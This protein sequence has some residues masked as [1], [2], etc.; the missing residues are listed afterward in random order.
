MR[1]EIGKTYLTVSGRK[2][3]IIY[4]SDIRATPFLGILEA[5]RDG[6][7]LYPDDIVWYNPNGTHNEKVEGL[8]LEREV[9]CRGMDKDTLTALFYR[10][11]ELIEKD[12]KF[13]D[14]KND[15]LATK[16]YKYGKANGKLLA[17][18]DVLALI[19]RLREERGD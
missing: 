9:V 1:I 5:K 2:C 11:V 10:V 16:A 15:E 18:N 8:T 13:P 19:N 3:K 4:K 7:K 14:V 17:Y 12:S 6:E